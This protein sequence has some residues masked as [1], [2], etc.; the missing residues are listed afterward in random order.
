MTLVRISLMTNNHE[1]LFMLFI[2]TCV[3]LVTCSNLLLIFKLGCFTFSLFEEF[4]IYCHFSLLQVCDLHLVS[5]WDLFPHSLT[6]S[7][8][9]NSSKVYEVQFPKFSFYG[10]NFWYHVLEIVAALKIKKD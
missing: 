9:G 3:S 8:K 6:V 10:L 4:L 7:F 2:A 1:P 5:G